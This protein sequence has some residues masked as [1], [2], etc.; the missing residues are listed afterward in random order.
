MRNE[1][2]RRDSEEGTTRAQQSVSMTCQDA[3]GRQIRGQNWQVDRWCHWQCND[4]TPV[5]GANVASDYPGCQNNQ[6]RLILGVA[7]RLDAPS[8]CFLFGGGGH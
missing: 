5:V 6:L 8:F 4:I 7:A 1:P 2:R 3:K